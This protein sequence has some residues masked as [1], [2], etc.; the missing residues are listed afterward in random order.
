VPDE[1]LLGIYLNDHLALATA[2]ERLA[3]RMCKANADTD[4]GRT[5][6]RLAAELAEERVVV[7]RVIEALGHR[8]SRVKPVAAAAGERLGLLKLNG[9]L[10]S[11][12]P[13]SRVL[14]LEGLGALL[15]FN[16]SLWRTLQETE[17]LAARL[18]GVVDLDR[19]TE[20][21]EE[22]RAQVERFRPKAARTAFVG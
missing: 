14:E 3:R 17:P 8:R 2:A 20:R 19:L 5:L 18:D 21:A 6:E 11:Y 16:S 9:R 1:R 4:L 12:S 22:R 13:L 10:T 15:G 7:T